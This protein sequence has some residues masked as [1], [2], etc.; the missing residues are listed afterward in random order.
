ML[1]AMKPMIVMTAQAGCVETSQGN[2]R[3]QYSYDSLGHQ[4]MTTKWVDECTARVTTYEYDLL[5]RIIEERV[6]DLS[7]VLY[8]C[9]QYDYDSRGN[10]CLHVTETSQGTAKTETKYDSRNRP[11]WHKDALGHVTVTEYD[12]NL[13]HGILRTTITDPLNNQTITTQNS[14]GQCIEESRRDATG[15]LRAQS[16]YVYDLAGHKI[17]QSDT[18][19]ATGLPNRTVVTEWIY[20]S[21]GRVVRLTEAV[22]TPEQK[23]T[24]YTY[25]LKGQK[26]TIFL[27]GDIELRHTYDH[28]GR[29][30]R[31]S[32][33]DNTFDYAYTYDLNNNV[34]SVLD[35]L[36][37]TVTQREYDPNNRMTTEIL[38]NALALSYGY[39]GLGRLLHVTLPDGSGVTYA[40]DGVHLK[41]VSRISERPYQH[42]YTLYDLSGALLKEISPVGEIAYT[43]DLM[44]RPRDIRSFHFTETIPEEGYDAVGNLLQKT[45]KDIECTTHC[46]YTYDPLYQLCTETVTG[47]TH[48]EY[49]YDSLH[50]RRLRNK[51]EQITN[52]LNQLLSVGETNYTYDR[53]GNLITTETPTTSVNYGYD[54]MGRLTSLTR[55]GKTVRYQ[56]DSFNRR[57]KKSSERVEELYLYIDQ[58]EVGKV[59]Q[60]KIVQ[61]RV[62]GRGKGA[63]IGSAIALELDDK[64][65][66]PIHD[67]SGH[68]SVL[69][70]LETK[71]LAEAYTY[72]AFGE[73]QRYGFGTTNPWRFSSKRYDPE[74]GWIYF[75]RR[76]YDPATGRW[77]TPDPI[78]FS[79]GPNL[80]AYVK[81]NPLT[82]FD[83]YGLFL[84]TDF[85]SHDSICSRQAAS[86]TELL[87]Y[88]RVQGTLQ[89]LAGLTEASLGYGLALGTGWTGIG[90]LVGGVMIA[91]GMDHYTAGMSTAFSG[92]SQSTLTVQGLQKGGLSPSQSHMVDNSMSIVATMGAGAFLKTIQ[93]T[94]PM[95]GNSAS[96]LTP[97]STNLAPVV[98]EVQTAKSYKPFTKRNARHNLIEFTGMDPGK[99]AHAHHVFPQ[100]FRADFWKKGINIDD[101]HNLTWWPTKAMSPDNHHL[102]RAKNY[103]RSWIEF[104][105]NE[106]KDAKIE[107]ILE[108]G[109]QL[110]SENKFKINY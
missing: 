13:V 26:E 35:K 1:T 48:Q 57:L 82:H 39:D 75:G 9:D 23:R 89:G 76:Y 20:D 24:S 106:L 83:P 41:A 109:M 95:L 67:H 47:F 3:T 15:Q 60:N 34:L 53:R 55:D 8:S 88:P 29:L 110:M 42:Q 103:N 6:K 84:C 43:W 73:E 90:A 7:G 74:S 2:Q 12:E 44:K 61:L 56:Y 54:A 107:E 63:E 101:P 14:I 25:N 28:L 81:N 49:L 71:S 31:Y 78:G 72:T 79:D 62:L 4:Y 108:K 87:G 65:Y 85:H 69:I 36:T 17:S 102:L 37:Q 32:A 52:H 100:E 38:A 97:K 59:E 33:S 22:G 51:Q 5:D 21:M 70:D 105:E 11:V 64:I 104:V 19:M 94:A 92:K 98:E 68:V 45:R 91:H 18:V 66:V 30:K 58:K 77:T 16:T 46:Q 10:R 27:P 40:Y 99:T 86:P 50:N 96:P 93:Q 80:Y